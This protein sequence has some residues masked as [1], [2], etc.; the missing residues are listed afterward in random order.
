MNYTLPRTV[1]VGGE[2]YAIRTD[3]RVILTILELLGDPDLDDQLKAQWMLELFYPQPPKTN[4]REAITACYDFID[5]ESGSKKK[6]PRVMDWEQD[7]RFIVAPVNR[8]LGYEC[9]EVLYDYDTNT[10]GVHWWTFMGAYME[11]GGD[12]MFSQI[13][14]IRDKQASGKKLEKYEKDFLARN[15]DIITLR[16]K[17]SEAENDLAAEW[18]NT[19]REKNG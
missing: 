14:S 9:R 15:R 7:F 13:V 4:I 19:G 3:F 18:M 8:V 1:S 6:S 12:C 11:I 16:Q 5:M 2:E 10:G 17:L